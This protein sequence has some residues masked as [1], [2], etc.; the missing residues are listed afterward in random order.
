MQL[1]AYL[2]ES[3]KTI[4]QFAREIGTTPQAIH[5]YISGE[6]TPRREILKRII[7][8]SKGKVRLEDLIQVEAA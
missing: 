3:G 5:R 7:D 8:H 1:G 6:R 4:P 2:Q